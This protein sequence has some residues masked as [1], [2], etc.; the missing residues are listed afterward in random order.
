MATAL[1]YP[2]APLPPSLGPEPRA[3]LRQL[4]DALDGSP[5]L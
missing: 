1:R 3:A 4:L 5:G 2:R